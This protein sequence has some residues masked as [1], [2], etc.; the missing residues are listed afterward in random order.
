MYQHGN[1][2]TTDKTSIDLQYVIDNQKNKKMIIYVYIYIIKTTMSIPTIST[3][4]IDD[5]NNDIDKFTIYDVVRRSSLVQKIKLLFVQDVLIE[6]K[7]ITITNIKNEKK[8]IEIFDE[9]QEHYDDVMKYYDTL[10]I[11]NLKDE[12]YLRKG[13]QKEI[14]NFMLPYNINT[15]EF[16]KIVYKKDTKYTEYMYSGGWSETVKMEICP[17]HQNSP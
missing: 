4:N 16:G 6:G 7:D 12:S 11:Y 14:L 17:I 1:G 10:T 15:E 8:L 3:V 2:F 9:Y 5:S 13:L